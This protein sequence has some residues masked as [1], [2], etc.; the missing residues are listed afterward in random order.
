LVSCARHVASSSA[1]AWRSSRADQHPVGAL[2]LLEPLER[3]QELAALLDGLE[4]D[5]SH[6][7]ATPWPP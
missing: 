4:A 1:S 3:G 5:D 7:I 6:A 2:Q